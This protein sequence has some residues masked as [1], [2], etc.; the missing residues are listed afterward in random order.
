[1]GMGALSL[2]PLFWEAQGDQEVWDESLDKQR[3]CWVPP[4]SWTPA[5]LAG[6]M[7]H[8]SLPSVL[9]TELIS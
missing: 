7:L 4:S 9:A 8:P 6:A 1:M 5:G 3:L 2:E